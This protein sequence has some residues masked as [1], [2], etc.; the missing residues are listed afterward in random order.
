MSKI[1]KGQDGVQNVESIDDQDFSIK[2]LIEKAL[3]KLDA[4]SEIEKAKME[5]I[6]NDHL[7]ALARKHKA[8]LTQKDGHSVF[9]LEFSTQTLVQELSARIFKNKES[10]KDSERTLTVNLVIITRNLIFELARKMNNDRETQFRN[11]ERIVDSDSIESPNGS[12][13]EVI[14]GILLKGAIEKL[15][16]TLPQESEVYALKHFGGFTEEEIA[17]YYQ[18]SRHQIRNKLISANNFIKKCM[19]V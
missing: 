10:L 2:L 1:T 6:L 7:Y 19:T 11:S 12:E 14:R 3:L 13:V 18:T 9:N 5:K 8:R 15:E 17:L 16:S 4:V